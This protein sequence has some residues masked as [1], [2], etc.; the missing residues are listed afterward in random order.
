MYGGEEVQ[1]RIKHTVRRRLRAVTF[2]L[3]SKAHVLDTIPA[4]ARGL[5]VNTVIIANW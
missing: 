5:H 4:F 1:Q 3:P 2:G